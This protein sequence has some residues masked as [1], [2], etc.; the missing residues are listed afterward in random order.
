[1]SVQVCVTVFFRQE[2]GE[3]SNIDV[4]MWYNGTEKFRE[5]LLLLIE[6]SSV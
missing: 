5:Y 2:E 4:C 1:M 6:C 3:K